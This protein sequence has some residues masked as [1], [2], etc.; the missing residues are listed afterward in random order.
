MVAVEE[1]VE[2]RRARKGTTK[3]AER[4]PEDGE[5]ALGGRMLADMPLV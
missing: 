4:M 1:W 5:E 3:D 2:G